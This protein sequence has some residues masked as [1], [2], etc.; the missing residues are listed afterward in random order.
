MRTDPTPVLHH[1]GIGTADPRRVG[2]LLAAL[3]A[4]HA[5]SGHADD[6]GVRCDFWRVHG[7]LIEVV[8]PTGPGSAVSALL[9]RHGGGL[10]HLAFR[11]GDLD[12][13]AERMRA[14][15]LVELET[16]PRRG[17]LPDMWVKFFLLPRPVNLLIELVAFDEAA[18]A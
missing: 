15:G 1:I 17:A 9:E 14:A 16:G 4:Q 11:V 3:G 2:A 8:T 12:E 7:S 18:P 10:H 13:A 6:Y 5:A